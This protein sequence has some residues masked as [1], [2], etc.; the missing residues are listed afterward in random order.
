M[1]VY[2]CDRMNACVRACVRAC[3]PEKYVHE[4]CSV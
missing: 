4:K 2:A 1:R 3:I